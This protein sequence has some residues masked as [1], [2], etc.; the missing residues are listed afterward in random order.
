MKQKK[1]L[2]SK[3]LTLDE[4]VS[5]NFQKTYRM[6]KTYIPKEPLENYM[7]KHPMLWRE[8]ELYK[9]RGW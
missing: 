3:Q 8:W 4:F 7:K 5:Q 2:T 9:D 6:W 1:Q